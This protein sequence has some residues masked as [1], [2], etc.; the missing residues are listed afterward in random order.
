M[1]KDLSC[2]DNVE[3]DTTIDPDKV[4]KPKPPTEPDPNP[5]PPIT[6]S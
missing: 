3:V 4:P 6:P 1:K 5:V 2:W